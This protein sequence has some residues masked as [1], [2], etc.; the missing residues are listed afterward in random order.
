MPPQGIC[1]NP[2]CGEKYV[3]WALLNFGHDTC[4]KCGYRIN[5]VENNTKKTETNKPSC[6]K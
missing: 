2:K 5:I 3:S 4:Q 1:S 6:S